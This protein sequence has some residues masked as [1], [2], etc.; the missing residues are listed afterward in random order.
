MRNLYSPIERIA[1]QI[2]AKIENCLKHS[3][4]LVPSDFTFT[5]FNVLYWVK[6]VKMNSFMT[7]S[8]VKHL[9]VSSRAKSRSM[10]SFDNTREKSQKLFLHFISLNKYVIGA[11][12]HKKNF[13]SVVKWKIALLRYM[14]IRDHRKGQMDHIW[15]GKITQAL[16]PHLMSSFL[17]FYS[18]MRVFYCCVKIW[19]L[20]FPG[21]EIFKYFI[22]YPVKFNFVEICQFSWELVIYIK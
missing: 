16:E 18:F 7:S 6:P 11:S 1:V 12:C 2:T 14:S 19:L 22:A 21:V 20:K 4:F 13:L 9:T 17:R 5:I 15:G 10:F 3:I 8:R